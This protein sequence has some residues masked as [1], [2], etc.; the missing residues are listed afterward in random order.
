[1]MHPELTEMLNDIA[2][3]EGISVLA[4]IEKILSNKI[5]IKRPSEL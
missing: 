1:M 4:L 2:A 3:A 5:G